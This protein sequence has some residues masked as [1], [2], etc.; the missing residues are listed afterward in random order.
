MLKLSI[1]EGDYYMNKNGFTLVELLA[2]VA[3]MAVII[4]IAI[5]NVTESLNEAKADNFGNE[6]NA[7]YSTAKTEYN[8]LKGRGKLKFHDIEGQRYGVFCNGYSDEEQPQ[9]VNAEPLST[10]NKSEMKYKIIIDMQGRVVYLYTTDGRFIY[11][12]ENPEACSEFKN[13]Y[14]FDTSSSKYR[15]GDEF[16]GG[17][18]YY[19]S[20]NEG[21]K[22]IWNQCN[23]Y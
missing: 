20:N 22:D 2:V 21:P 18:E 10:K 15:S 17:C 19:D 6:V 4:I 7:L 9:C 12:C 11:E 13:E 1:V 23:D 16:Y 14:I 3:I 8:L 5:P